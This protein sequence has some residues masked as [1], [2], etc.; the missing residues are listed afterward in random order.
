MKIRRPGQRLAALGD[1]ELGRLLDRV[2]GVAA[3]VGEPDHLGAGRLRLQQERGEVLAGERVAHGAEHLA[4][5]R[6]DDGGGV[7]LERVPEGVVGGQEEPGVAALR[8]HRAAG[9]LG[10]RVGVVG[11]VDRR[12]RAGLAGQV[13]GRR[14]GDEEDLVLLAADLVDR[15]RGRRGRH[16]DDDVDAVLVV[17]L[18]GDVRGDVGLVLVVGGDDLDVDALG[19]G[20]EVLDGHAR[21]DDRAFAGEVGVDPR[22][23]VEHADLD[24]D[25]HRRRGQEQ[26]RGGGERQDSEFHFGSSELDQ[27]RSITPRG[28]LAACRGWRRAPRSRIMSTTRPVSTT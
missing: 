3:G 20:V 14:P 7:L 6:L 9:A 19:G 25:G 21:G 15:Q 22:A 8:D 28:R 16:V 26:A 4:A 1:A 23:V 17:P 24:V 5:G 18:A 11:P 10:E 13:G 27:V 12:R 2:D